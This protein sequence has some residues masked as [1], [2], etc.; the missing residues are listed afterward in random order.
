MNKIIVQ[1]CTELFD[2]RMV[3]RSKVSIQVLEIIIPIG[4]YLL[5]A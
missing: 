2:G 5:H 4:T 3:A 1:L